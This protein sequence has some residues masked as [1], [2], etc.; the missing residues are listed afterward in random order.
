MF[1][2][3][4]PITSWNKT[5]EYVPICKQEVSNVYIYMCVY[6][7]KTICKSELLETSCLQMGT[8][9]NVLIYIYIY[10]SYTVSFRLISAAFRVHC[11]NSEIFVLVHLKQFISTF[12]QS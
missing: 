5:L 6:I 10:D 12:R 3:S 7:Y 11:N 9:S 2:G 8:Y 4:N 1:H